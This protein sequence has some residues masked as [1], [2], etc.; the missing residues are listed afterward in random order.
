MLFCVPDGNVVVMMTS[1]AVAAWIEMYKVLFTARDAESTTCTDTGNVPAWD[2]VPLK[3]PA[4]LRVKPLG[5]ADNAL[6]VYPGVPP[7]A[8]KEV[9]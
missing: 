2:G 5:R 9:L 1:G 8:D 6:H 7:E 4:V 3:T